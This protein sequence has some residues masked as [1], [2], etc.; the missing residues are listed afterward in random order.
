[1]SAETYVIQAGVRRA[2]A[3]HLLGYP[4]VAAELTDQLG[5]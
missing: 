2:F 4:T 3:A 1:M 5:V